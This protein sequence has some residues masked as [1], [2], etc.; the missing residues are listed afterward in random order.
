MIKAVKF[1]IWIT[2]VGNNRKDLAR[3]ATE[4]KKILQILNKCNDNIR[5]KAERFN[6]VQ[7]S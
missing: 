5:L 1:N 4:R 7:E 6:N 2:V 3:E